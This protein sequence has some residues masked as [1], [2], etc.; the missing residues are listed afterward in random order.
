MDPS[1]DGLVQTD[2]LVRTR[3]QGLALRLLILFS[4]RPQAPL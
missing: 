1:F 4:R 3:H 2:A